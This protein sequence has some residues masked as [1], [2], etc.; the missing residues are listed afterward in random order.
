[1]KTSAIVLLGALGTAIVLMVSF[2]IFV[3]S[4]V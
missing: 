3:G 1:M 2:I 4:V